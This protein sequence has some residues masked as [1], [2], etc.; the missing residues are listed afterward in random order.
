M[1]NISKDLLCIH[2][3]KNSAYAKSMHNKSNLQIL[4]TNPHTIALYSPPALCVWKHKETHE[5]QRGLQPHTRREGGHKRRAGEH[6]ENGRPNSVVVVY[7]QGAVDVFAQAFHV[8]SHDR[9]SDALFSSCQETWLI[10]KRHDS[11]IRDMTHTQETWLIHKR[12]DSYTRDM[13]HT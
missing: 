9:V 7:L 6:R 11:Y 12:H 10:H 8:S 3:K 1:H 5:T 2:K 13:T 4:L